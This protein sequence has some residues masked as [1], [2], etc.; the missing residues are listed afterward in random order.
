MSEVLVKKLGILV[1]QAFEKLFNACGLHG[2]SSLLKRS[3]ESQ[4]RSHTIAP[5][6][7]TLQPCRARYETNGT[8]GHLDASG[9][10]LEAPGTRACEGV[11][12]LWCGC[13]GPQQP[14]QGFL[15][16]VIPPL[17]G[18]QVVSR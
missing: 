7:Q 4:G 11:R 9:G 3:R 13:E 5:K 10:L 6:L 15:I 17:V 18:K 12:L 1:N 16:H 14:I 2:G 8:G